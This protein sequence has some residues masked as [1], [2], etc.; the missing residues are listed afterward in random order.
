MVDLVLMQCNGIMIFGG[1]CVSNTFNERWMRERTFGHHHIHPLHDACRTHTHQLY[2]LWNCYGKCC[3]TWIM[4]FLWHCVCLVEGGCYIAVATATAIV[5]VSAVWI[6]LRGCDGIL[7]LLFSN[8]KAFLRSSPF[9]CLRCKNC[10]NLSLDSFFFPFSQSRSSLFVSL[11]FCLSPFL[12]IIGSTRSGVIVR[13]QR[14]KCD[15]L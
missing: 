13:K 4:W 8:G 2:L 9:L 7:Y 14:W 10:R 6:E 11:F 5:T 1:L 15:W 3:V 12:C